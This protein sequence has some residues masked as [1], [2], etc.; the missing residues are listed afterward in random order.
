MARTVA[1][2]NLNERL[3][4]GYDLGTGQVFGEVGYDL[5]FSAVAVEPFAALAYVNVGG[6]SFTEAGGAAAL[7]VNTQAMGTTYATLGARMA[8]TTDMFGARLTPSLTLGWQH[9]FGDT[10]PASTM[11][12]LAGTT[13]F[14]ISG[15]PIATDML[16]VDAGLSYAL[17]QA[18]SLGVTYTG[19]YGETAAQSAFTAHFTARF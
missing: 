2:P 18:T 3:G 11:Q 1:F 7:A 4:A 5:S 12:F 8:T 6:A 13:P 10:I 15:A 9:A 17:S 14:G 19:Q 16:L